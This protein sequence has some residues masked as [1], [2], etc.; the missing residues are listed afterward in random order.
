MISCQRRH[1][2]FPL[3]RLLQTGF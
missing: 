1:F 2:I 3:P